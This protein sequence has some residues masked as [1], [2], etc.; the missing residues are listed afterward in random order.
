MNDKQ[1]AKPRIR[2]PMDRVN[3][4]RQG[5]WRN[6]HD[7]VWTDDIRAHVLQLFRDGATST[8]I[9]A[10]PFMPSVDAQANE[11]KRNPEFAAAVQ[12]ARAIGARAMLDE[13][14]D[15]ARQVAVADDDGTINVDNVRA[16]ESY[17]RTINGFVEKVAPREYGPLLKLGADADGAAMPIIQIVSFAKDAKQDNEA[18]KASG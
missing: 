16:A 4:R 17:A 5:N 12:E 10:T 9:D 3:A 2:T 15:L 11:C 7:F 1:A 18:D 6:R 8:E 13:A 14:N